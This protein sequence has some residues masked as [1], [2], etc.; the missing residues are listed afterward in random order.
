M[1]KYSIPK[2]HGC[3]GVWRVSAAS[4]FLVAVAACGGGGAPTGGSANSSGGTM[5]GSTSGT[6]GG[7]T[8]PTTGTAFT[9]DIILG[10]P[11]DTRIRVKLFS[12]TQSGSVQLSWGLQSAAETRSSLTALQA[13]EPL[14]VLV[15]GLQPDSAYRW[16][17]AFTASGSTSAVES[18]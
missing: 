11:E 10:A 18:N 5:G 3:N 8:T 1:N 4:L 15:E 2:P 12:A 16:K 7:T 17:L 13:G 6:S 14:E 9:G